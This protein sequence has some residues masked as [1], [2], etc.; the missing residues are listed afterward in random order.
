MHI[1]IS[2]VRAAEELAVRVGLVVDA[3]CDLPAE[4]LQAH[5]VR[6]LPIVLN[7]AGQRFIDRREPQA[8]QAFYQQQ[9]PTVLAGDHSQPLPVLELQQWLLEELVSEFDY[10]LCLTVCSQR[11]Q[12][13]EHAT[14]ASFGLLQCYRERRAAAG[15]TGPFAMRV[16]D[17]KSVFA[18]VGLLAAEALRLIGS[19]AHPNAIRT[20]LE[21]LAGQT[22]TFIVADDLA[23]LRQRG[24]Q[25]GDR[26]GLLDKVRGA[27]LGLGSL[28]DV[29]PVLSVQSGADKPVALSPSF[30]KAAEKLFAHAAKRVAANE[31]LAP[32][33]CLSYAGDLSVVRDLPGFAALE[34]L[35]AERA[36][37][38]QLSMLSATGAI[39]LGRGALSLAYAAP[40]KA[41]D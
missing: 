6:V 7:V 39:N 3:T 17:S 15:L 11:S 34:Q 41:F 8:T 38:L 12:I 24:F 29:K 40:A 20:R 35:C 19:G 16:I 1:T 13:F 28:L 18:G 30:D 22:C 33:L 4:F 9:L 21:Q 14:Q 23:H 26:S 31:L 27:A 10:L 37:A 32:Q 5:G 25:K 2:A 36:V